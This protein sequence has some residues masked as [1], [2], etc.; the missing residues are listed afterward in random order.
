MLDTER[1]SAG[2]TGFRGLGKPEAV[3]V[4]PSHLA[5]VLARLVDEVGTAGSVT[6]Y[7]QVVSERAIEVLG[8]SAAALSLANGRGQLQVVAW[9]DDRVLDLAQVELQ[10]HRGGPG[11]D[12][13]DG[14]APV[15]NVDAAE[16]RRRWPTFSRRAREAGFCSVH[17][18]PFRVSGRIGGVINL[19]CI[20]RHRFSARDL[21]VCRALVEVAR[22]DLRRAGIG[23]ARRYPFRLLG[24]RYQMSDLLGRGGLT[25][26]YLGRDT[27]LG[28]PVAIK[29]PRT[30]RSSGAHLAARFR[31]EAHAVG[32]LKHPGIV[33]VL[34]TGLSALDGS[35]PYIVMERVV[36]ST[37]Q[38]RL[39]RRPLL[40]PD[41]AVEITNAV[42]SALTYSHDH[43]VV[44]GDIS[45]RNVMVTTD[46]VVKVLDFGNCRILTDASATVT[47]AVMGTPSYLAPEQAKGQ[48]TDARTDLYSTGCLLYELLTGRPPFVGDSPIALAYQHVNETP[49]PPSRYRAGIRADLDAA[50][51]RALAKPPD[52]RYQEAGQF[53]DDLVAA[54]NGTL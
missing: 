10:D 3:V 36:G 49:Q 22:A 46:G 2:A 43:G 29:M 39:R 13:H 28:R 38:E 20:R 44:H 7:L 26:V 35:E 48:P 34:D 52:A 14:R 18:V 11:I 6:D 33:A 23:P 54:S 12:C 1:R 24:G 45:A 42:L 53:R 31:R 37:V 16:A 17:A 19:Y 9:T 21:S 30:D 8:V 4:E 51:L 27:C 32:R 25:E 50:V 40:G 5:G 47:Q 41:A 15:V